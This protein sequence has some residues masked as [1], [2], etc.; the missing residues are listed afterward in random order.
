M[1]RFSHWEYYDRSTFWGWRREWYPVYVEVGAVFNITIRCKVVPQQDPELARI[2][3]ETERMRAIKQQLDAEADMLDSYVNVARKQAELQGLLRLTR[4]ER[5]TEETKLI[6]YRPQ[7]AM[8][9]V[10]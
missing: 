6:P 10:R 7:P 4:Q 1:R 3:R 9:K 2:A 8:A 5:T